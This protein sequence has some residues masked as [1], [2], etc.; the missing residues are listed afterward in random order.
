MLHLS[1]V[2][3]V[4]FDIKNKPTRNDTVL[5]G[6]KR[7]EPFRGQFIFDI[8]KNMVHFC[9]TSRYMQVFFFDIKNKQTLI[10]KHTHTKCVCADRRCQME[11][12][13]PTCGHHRGSTA[14]SW[15]RWKRCGRRRWK[16]SLNPPVGACG[17]RHG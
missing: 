3:Q 14:P 8:K 7:N 16:H 11:G 15:C 4:F 17:V 10:F 2:H 1:K 6:L 12:I 9:H 13:A 5:L